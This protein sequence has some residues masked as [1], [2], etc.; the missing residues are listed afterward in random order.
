[1][2][3]AILQHVPFEGPAA[4]ANWLD[5][6]GVQPQVCALYLQQALPR[7]DEFDL[8]VVLG[9]PMSVHDEVALPWMS[10]EKRLIHQ[11]LMAGK[12]ILGICLG[13]QLL[14]EAL[15]ASVTACSQAEIGW[16]PLEKHAD[17]ARSP[18]GRMLPQRLMALHWHGEQFDIPHGALPLYGSAAC[19]NQGFVWRERAI[20]LQCH[21][22]TT[23]GSVE[24]L[25]EH[26]A[27]ELTRPGAV[28]DSAA[29]R[30][31]IPHCGSANSTLFRVLDYLTGG[32]AHL[33]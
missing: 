9:G 23:A 2:R 29:L 12:R 3:V 30:D 16:W 22:E 32:H 24:A 8:L 11:A 17:S 4:I 28:Q 33:T 10:A 25:L 18:L 15:G 6:Y 1:M 21:L 5:G 19:A 14:A 27:D 26:C 20:A 7:L 13:G 31:G